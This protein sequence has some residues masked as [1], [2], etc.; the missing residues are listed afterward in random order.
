MNPPVTNAKQPGRHVSLGAGWAE[1]PDD[2]GSYQRIGDRAVP[3]RIDVHFESVD[4]QPS[5]ELRLEVVD[6]IPQCREMRLV[7]A[8]DG[9]EV[10]ALDLDAI[11][12]RE[13]VEEIYALFALQVVD[14]EAGVVK[15]VLSTSDDAHVGAVQAFQRARKGKSARKITPTFLAGI[16]KVYRNNLSKNPTQ[17]VQREYG[18][19]YRTAAGYV[20]RARA[21]GLLKQ[22][23]GGRKGA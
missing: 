22:T 15:A 10:K 4:G 18:V 5:L 9:R 16:A 14:E 7:S 19:E 20:Q 23:S 11:K 17:A 6:G 21:A 12:L 2:F 3:T 8:R 1:T 13:W